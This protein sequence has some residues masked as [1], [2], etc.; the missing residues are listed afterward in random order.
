MTLKDKLEHDEAKADATLLN[1]RLFFWNW[2][3][4]GRVAR[5]LAVVALVCVCAMPQH[6][7]RHANH[8]P[9]PL[10]VAR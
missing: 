9:A 4:V 6:A 1:S 3:W 8:R 2:R 10:T 7:A 5:W